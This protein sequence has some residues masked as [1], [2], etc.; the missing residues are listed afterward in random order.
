[1]VQKH[2]ATRLHYDF[3]LEI[4]GVL[5]LRGR[6]VTAIDMRC[7]LGE[8]PAIKEYGF[9]DERGRWDHWPA[10]FV[11]RVRKP[12]EGRGLRETR[13]VRRVALL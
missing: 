8:Y 1:M 9:V 10:G 13:A 6:I 3:R 7:R 12:H 5:N 2:A 4:A 11:A